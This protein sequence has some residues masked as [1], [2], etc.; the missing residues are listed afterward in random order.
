LCA[1]FFLV[2]PFYIAVALL[3]INHPSLAAIAELDFQDINHAFFQG[4]I[5]NGDAHFK[6]VIEVA[7]HPVRR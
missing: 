2:A 6:P 5:Q 4:G 3:L 7:G 1:H